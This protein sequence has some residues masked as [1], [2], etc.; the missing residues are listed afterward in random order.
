MEAQLKAKGEKEVAAKAEEGKVKA[1]LKKKEEEA[2]LK[3]KAA[4]KEREEAREEARKKLEAIRRVTAEAK[5]RGQF[6]AKLKKV[7][8]EKRKGLEKKLA[9]KPETSP[10]ADR[11]TLPTRQ[12]PTTSTSPT[13][14]SVSTSTDAPIGEPTKSGKGEEQEQSLEELVRRTVQK[15]K[16]DAQSA[17]KLMATARKDW[18]LL[19]QF[20]GG[21]SRKDA[22]EVAASEVERERE[23]SWNIADHTN[24]KSHRPSPPKKPQSF[25]GA[26]S[27]RS[28]DTPIITQVKT[29][30]DVNRE[31]L[32][33]SRIAGY[34]PSEKFDEGTH[35][36]YQAFKRKFLRATNME[37]FT[38]EDKLAEFAHWF[39][40]M[41]LRMVPEQK[42]GKTAEEAIAQAWLRMDDYF[43]AQQ[44]TPKE[45]LRK[46]LDSGPINRNDAK[47]HTELALALE[48]EIDEA[49][50]TN[51]H[52]AYDEPHVINAVLNTKVQYYAEEFWRKVVEEDGMATFRRLIRGIELRGA[53][54]RKKGEFIRNGGGSSGNGGGGSGGSGGGGKSG[55]GGGEGASK[56][57]GKG[58]KGGSGNAREGGSPSNS[59]GGSGKS[60]GGHEHKDNCCEPSQQGGQT[61]AANVMMAQV[62]A[63]PTTGV[64]Y[65]DIVEFSPAQQ[66]KGPCT[67]CGGPHEFKACATMYMNYL[68]PDGNARREMFYKNQLCFNCGEYDHITANCP[69]ERAI[70]DHCNGN[71]LSCLH[72]DRQE[73][74]GERKP[75]TLGDQMPVSKAPPQPTSRPEVVPL[76]LPG[77][78]ASSEKSPL[79]DRHPNIQEVAN[80]RGGKK[81]RVAVHPNGGRRGGNVLA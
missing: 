12:K 10:V 46:I 32:A 7:E 77:N 56:Q 5:S 38:A 47:A 73:K 1:E 30:E 31:T 39:A 36:R 20:E 18:G 24:R 19:N 33:R 29:A 72:V 68:F 59:S 6:T 3:I 70:C 50:A 9:E 81:S 15:R 79:T 58:Q 69:H 53:I 17:A 16:W 63:A 25:N 2:A 48:E 62:E 28:S 52:A 80:G 71:H 44:L 55:G 65:N 66:Q 43:G 35:L 27:T 11:T 60:Y 13:P 41:A 37:G 23:G 54:L 14:V 76:L 4:E 49:E 21:F 51:C 34:R 40:G 57:G 8:E 64:R 75:M 22:V 74:N 61:S 26:D 78:V 67:F 42:S 45:S